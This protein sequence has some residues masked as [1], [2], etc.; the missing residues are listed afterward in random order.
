M[1]TYEQHLKHSRQ[2]NKQRLNK[3]IQTKIK[4]KNTM[5]KNVYK[6]KNGK[7]YTHDYPKDGEPI[8]VNVFVADTIYNAA[9]KR[10]DKFGRE[11]RALECVEAKTKNGYRV[12]KVK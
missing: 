9:T 2:V 8:L 3:F 11:F 4:E 10:V 1:A 5:I 7:Y 12:Y 6:N